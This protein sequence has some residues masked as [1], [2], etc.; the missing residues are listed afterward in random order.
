MWTECHKG[1]CE[2]FKA[3]YLVYRVDK[4]EES[5]GLHYVDKGTMNLCNITWKMIVYV[6]LKGKVL[7]IDSWGSY[8]N[9][10]YRLCS[11][12]QVKTLTGF[13]EFM[14]SITDGFRNLWNS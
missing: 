12:V 14:E 8:N 6:N 13:S 11:A 3:I 7:E 10:V 1:P 9:H 2:S 5:P 4:C